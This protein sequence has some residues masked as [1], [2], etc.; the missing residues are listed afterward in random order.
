[1]T[2][3]VRSELS[4]EDPPSTEAM[5]WRHEEAITEIKARLNRIEHQLWLVLLGIVGVLGGII[6]QAIRGGG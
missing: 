6:A 1:M 4:A 3:P 2:P 5:V